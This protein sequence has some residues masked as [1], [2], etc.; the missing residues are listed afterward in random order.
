MATTATSS[1]RR[2]VVAL[3]AALLATAALAWAV[4]VDLSSGMAGMAHYDVMR[5]PRF[6]MLLAMWSVM[7]PAM[8]LPSVAPVAS[9]Y[10]RTLAARTTGAVRAS[11]MAGFVVGYLTVWT[12]F[13]VA[14][15]GAQTG[16]G[17]TGGEFPSLLRWTAPLGLLVAGL[18]QFSRLKDVCLRQCRTPMAFLLHVASFRGVTRD[19]RAG[20]YH[21]A[22]CVGC[23]LALMGV[24]VFLGSMSLLL[25]GVLTAV[26]LL[27]K[28]WRH[29]RALARGVGVALIALAPVT[30]W[31]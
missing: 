9:A 2:S 7:M 17:A 22:Y 21:G 18:F 26:V 20:V 5:P 10:L 30:L 1:G 27:E 28:T 8:M 31:I 13:S 12:A 14:A 11:R 16:I 3:W 6:G 25:M 24:I 23:C 19:V 29:G 15:A 4:T